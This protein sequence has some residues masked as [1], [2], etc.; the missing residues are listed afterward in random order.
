MKLNPNT[1]V[2]EFRQNGVKINVKHFR[3]V[4][5]DLLGKEHVGQNPCVIIP[6]FDVS[7]FSQMKDT[8]YKLGVVVP[9]S[10]SKTPM[11]NVR[12]P[13]KVKVLIPA[14]DIRKINGSL[15]IAEPCGGKTE[16]EIITPEGKTYK[17]ESFCNPKD[18]FSH[19]MARKIAIGRALSYQ[20]Q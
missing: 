8:F 16:V 14:K 4:D 9:E 7:D 12:I 18:N 6:D 20:E 1:T 2:A 3:Y 19:S 10:Q 17:G 5:R 11:V 15:N 13:C